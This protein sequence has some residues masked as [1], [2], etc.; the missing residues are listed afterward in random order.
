MCL[1]SFACSNLNGNLTRLD[2][3]TQLFSSSFTE[4]TSGRGRSGHHYCR[5]F[6]F[7]PVPC[8][9]REERRDTRT[10]ARTQRSILISRTSPDSKSQSVPLSPY[11]TFCLA[12]CRGVSFSIYTNF[13]GHH[14]PSGNL[15]VLAI[16][17]SPYVMSPL[18][19]ASDLFWSRIRVITV[20]HGHLSHARP[21]AML[22]VSWHRPICIVFHRYVVCRYHK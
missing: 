5:E 7:S 22:A 13:S 15:C 2:R 9:A 3:T 21:L 12:V 18:F 14:D 6:N 16:H 1:C 20:K 10:L 17:A 8:V 11:F 19:S 4:V